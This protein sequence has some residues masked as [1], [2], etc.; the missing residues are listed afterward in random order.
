MLKHLTAFHLIRLWRG[1]RGNK[2]SYSGIMKSIHRHAVT[3][4][5]VFFFIWNAHIAIWNCTIEESVTCSLLSS[6]DVHWLS[7][8]TKSLFH[9]PKLLVQK[10]I[11]RT[12][13][14]TKLKN[15]NWLPRRKICAQDWFR[16]LKEKFCWFSVGWTFWQFMS[17]LTLS[18]ILNTFF[19]IKNAFL[20]NISFIRWQVSDDRDGRR[21]YEMYCGSCSK[22]ISFSRV[23]C[24]HKNTFTECR[25]SLCFDGYY[26]RH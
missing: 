17:G 20:D 15:Y 25:L 22:E 14:A 5:F 18:N 12:S 21:L 7:H 4:C 11:W 19:S 9:V 16:Y 6:S 10:V 3:S 23:Q 26:L 13:H 8:S 2:H 1:P 24:S